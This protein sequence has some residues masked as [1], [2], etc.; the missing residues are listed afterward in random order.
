MNCKATVED[1]EVDLKEYY[2]NVFDKLKNTFEHSHYVLG[3]GDD[4]ELETSLKVD[5]P[6]QK[7]HYQ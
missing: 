6:G 1:L 2:Y 3:Y 7:P 5:K 4:Y